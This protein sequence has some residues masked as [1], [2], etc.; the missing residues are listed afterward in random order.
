MNTIKINTEVEVDE[1]TPPGQTIEGEI[2]EVTA[3]IKDD[4]VKFKYFINTQYIKSILVYEDEII[5]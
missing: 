3:Y 2:K 1:N 5:E 4:I